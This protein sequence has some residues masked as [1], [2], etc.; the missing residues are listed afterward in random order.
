MPWLALI[1]AAGR[2]ILSNAFTLLGI[3][4]HNRKDLACE[5]VIKVEGH[6]RVLSGAQECVPI[7]H[8]FM[9][10]FGFLR[11]VLHD[12]GLHIKN[13]ERLSVDRLECDLAI[14]VF[15]D[16]NTIRNHL[17]VGNRLALHRNFELRVTL[18]R[19]GQR[20]VEYASSWATT[21][22]NRDFSLFA[23]LKHSVLLKVRCCAAA[24]GLG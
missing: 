14:R 19:E 17:D 8:D 13:L 7:K 10:E 9:L 21:H 23:W 22:T 6:A 4:L 24:R 12:S 5:G 16:A 18:N 20:L 15:I 2:G 3:E 11:D 1:R